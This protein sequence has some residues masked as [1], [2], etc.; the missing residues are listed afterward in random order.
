MSVTRTPEGSAAVYN[1]IHAIEHD[2]A[3]FLDRFRTKLWKMAT[4]E[5]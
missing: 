1:L 4:K 2:Q 3:N 5:D